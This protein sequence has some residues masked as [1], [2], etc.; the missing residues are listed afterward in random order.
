MARFSAQYLL[1]IYFHQY[2]IFIKCL[3]LGACT[4]LASLLVKPYNL[5]IYNYI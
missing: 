4:S 3:L 5:L 1:I 2:L